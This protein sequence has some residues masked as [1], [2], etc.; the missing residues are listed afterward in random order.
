MCLQ[1][2]G[3]GGGGE[4][5]ELSGPASLSV[6]AVGEPEE[7][8]GARAGLRCMKLKGAAATARSMPDG[9]CLAARIRRT[10]SSADHQSAR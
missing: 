4:G 10:S 7:G 5:G 1:S 6:L 3:A 9:A 2:R 8:A